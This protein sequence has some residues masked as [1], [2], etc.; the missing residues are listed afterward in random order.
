MLT[1]TDN[2]AQLYRG[3]QWE[4]PERLNMAAQ[5]C[6][7]WAARVPGRVAIID[8]TGSERRD[9]T[10]GALRRMADG[11]AH[12][13]VRRSAVTG[14]GFCGRNRPG[15]RRRISPAGSS[16]RFPFR[17]SSCSGPRR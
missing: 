1:A 2:Y 6:D 5:V 13:L 12:E 15:R 8:M 10:Y 11:L 4:I 9:V 3:F 7:D 17:C 16:V 14:S